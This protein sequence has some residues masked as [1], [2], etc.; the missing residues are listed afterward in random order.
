MYRL[1]RRREPRQIIIARGDEVQVFHL[2]GWAV[3]LGFF[4]IVGITF[5]LAASTTYVL[6]RDDVL[7]AMM[8]RQTRMQHGYEDRIATLRLQIDR[9]TSRQLLDQEAF[10][11]RMEELMRRQAALES[12]AQSVQGVM[13]RARQSGLAPELVPSRD[14]DPVI[15]GA[16]APSAR[17]RSARIEA[18]LEGVDRGL[19]RMAVTQDEALARI[20]SRSREQENEIRTTVAD[21]GISTEQ[22]AGPRPRPARA[23]AMG[24]PLVPIGGTAAVSA[25]EARADRL[26]EQLDYLD[27]LRRGLSSLPLRRPVR[28]VDVSSGFGTRRDPFLGI[29]ALHSGIDFRGDTGDPVAATGAGTVTTAGRQ[30]GYGLM[31]EVDH[32]NGLSTRYGH[33]SAILVREGQRV[34]AG[35]LVGRVGSTGRSTGPHLHWETRVNDTAVNPDRFMRAGQRL[36]VW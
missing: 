18:V 6:F 14:A 12:R 24:G 35:Q 16:I 36:G 2:R 13:E 33:L 20:E 22:L 27:R 28:E 7:A 19:A 21:L 10:N 25:L 4:L 3:A 15:T 29:W 8:A 26:R 32:G 31:V 17:S 9:V 23:P 1:G 5:W 34:T 11:A 30:G